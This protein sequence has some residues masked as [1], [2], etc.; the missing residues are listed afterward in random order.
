MKK[1]LCILLFFLITHHSMKAQSYSTDGI[2][3]NISLLATQPY[4]PTMDKYIAAISD[5]LGLDPGLKAQRGFGA[6]MSVSFH[7]EKTEFE[8][9]GFAAKSSYRSSMPSIDPATKISCSD[10]ELHMGLNYFPVNWI[11]IG[12][13]FA[14]V[15]EQNNTLK[16]FNSNYITQAED[17]TDLNIFKGYSVGIKAIAGLNIPILSDGDG[18]VRITPFYQ[19][20]LSRYN[21]YKLFDNV[22]T[23]YTGERKTTISQAGILV[24][25]V[26]ALKKE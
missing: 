21:Y 23:N 4:R 20:G 25:I 14:A 5:T 19:L 7:H 10:I 26:L 18:F 22:L 16:N 9:G 24:G 8:L 12:A 3:L 11:I 1:I 15:A 2:Y 17:N 13:H 6:G